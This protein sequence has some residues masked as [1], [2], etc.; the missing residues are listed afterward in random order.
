[1]DGPLMAHDRESETSDSWDD[2]DR[3]RVARMD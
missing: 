1:M 2:L 3:Y